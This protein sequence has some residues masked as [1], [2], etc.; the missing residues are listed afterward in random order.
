MRYTLIEDGA[1]LLAEFTPLEDPV[2][3]AGIMRRKGSRLRGLEKI[4]RRLG[5]EANRRKL[6]K[7]FDIDPG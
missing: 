7:H 2:Y 3:I 6:E 5:R 4:N 1:R